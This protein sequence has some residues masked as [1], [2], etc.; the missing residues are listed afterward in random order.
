MVDGLRIVKA[1]TSHNVYYKNIRDLKS[2]NVDLSQRYK[3]TLEN[4]IIDFNPF[5]WKEVV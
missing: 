4:D 2:A 1:R 5:E 3:L